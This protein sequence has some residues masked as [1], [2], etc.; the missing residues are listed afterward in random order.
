MDSVTKFKGRENFQAFLE[1]VRQVEGGTVSPG[2]A[3][4]I[5]RVTRQGV[6][7]L[8]DTGHLRAWEFYEGWPK[9][10]VTYREISVRDLITYGVKTGKIEAPADC[11]LAFPRLAEEIERAKLLLATAA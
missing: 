1:A 11:A 4:A 9:A 7:K 3:A 2:G 6:E 8:I 10:R 5:L